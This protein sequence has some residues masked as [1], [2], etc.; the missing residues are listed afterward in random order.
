[1]MRTCVRHYRLCAA[2]ANICHV[3]GAVRGVCRPA[4]SPHGGAWRANRHANRE[5]GPGQA[6]EHD[7]PMA[8]NKGRL[9]TKVNIS[10]EA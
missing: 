5:H 1:M 7:A 10:L 9:M 2:R 8:N 6:T 3:A 4:L